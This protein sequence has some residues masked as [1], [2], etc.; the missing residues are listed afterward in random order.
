MIPF[1][2]NS[3]Y[4]KEIEY[5]KDAFKEGKTSGD[6]KYSKL[7][8]KLME[9]KFRAKKIL[10][11]TSGTHALELAMLLIDLK[12]NDEV[13]MPSYTFVST[14][15][16][17][18]LRGAKPVFC[19]I[20]SDTLN[21]DEKKI[22][23][24]ITE[25][26]KAILPVHYAGQSCEMDVIKKIAK[27]NDLF[28]IED[29]AQGVNAK[30][31]DQYLGTIGDIG[32]YSFHETKNYSMGEGGAIVINNETFI[33][34][35]EI[36]R[37]KGTNR[38]KFIKGEVDKYTWVDVGSSYLPSDINAAILYAQLEIVDQIQKRRSSIFNK[39]ME[40]LTELSESGYF[41]MPRIVKDVEINY[42]IFYL[43][44]N[45]EK[46]RDDLIVHLKKREIMATFHYIPL[47]KSEFYMKNY[48]TASLPI[49]ERLSS[50]IIRLPLFY[51][52]T[53]EEQNR[54]ITHIVGW[55]KLK[56]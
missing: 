27:E 31:K 22:E 45:N 55:T 51:E 23:P 21:I 30:Y 10:L 50:K 38:S 4:G 1:N 16:A 8:A 34:R 19:D 12:R 54:I 11:T 32:C 29:A 14:A 44:M 52:L 49:T 2:K 53:E 35:A 7:C 24:L 40:N 13:I 5:I 46:D 17:V 48:C 56:Q 42:H 15:N 36:I 6:G 41:S 20:R 43:I 37:E 25:K 26:T 28:V 47:H 39:Y 9:T 18:V 33:E 3:L